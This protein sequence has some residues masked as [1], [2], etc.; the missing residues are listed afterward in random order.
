M[1]SAKPSVISFNWPSIAN[2]T[3]T[4]LNFRDL[5]SLISNIS[6]TNIKIKQDRG[7]PCLFSFFGKSVKVLSSN[8]IQDRLSFR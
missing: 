5:L 7:L 2:V 6:I 3:L 1:S 4:G 8:I